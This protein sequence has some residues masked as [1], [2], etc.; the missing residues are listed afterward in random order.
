MMVDLSLGGVLS[1][2]KELYEIVIIGGGPAGLS[3]A[4]YLSVMG[5]DKITI[6]E[7]KP[8]LGG[9]MRY[10]IP[11]YRLPDKALDKDIIL[12]S[13]RELKSKLQPL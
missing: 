11:A 4:Y 9:V 8:R 7:S 6:F 3:A 12:Y 10:G 5:Y 1:E 13:P 2:K